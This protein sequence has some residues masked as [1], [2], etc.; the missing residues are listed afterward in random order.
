MNTRMHLTEEM[1]ISLI[2]KLQ[3]WVDT[4]KLE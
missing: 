1:V 4:G 3:H 2:D